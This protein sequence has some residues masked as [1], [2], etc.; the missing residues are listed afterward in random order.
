M[1]AREIV[2]NNGCKT[3]IHINKKYIYI[4]T[5]TRHCIRLYTLRYFLSNVIF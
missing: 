3:D 2:F 1:K 5:Y 4:F